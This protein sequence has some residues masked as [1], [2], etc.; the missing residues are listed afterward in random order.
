VLADIAVHRA[1]DLADALAVLAAAS[2]GERPSVLAGG[3]DLMVLLNARVWMPPRVLDIHGLD[4]LRGI[5]ADGDRLIIGALAT[6]Q[7]MIDSELVQRLSPALVEASLTVGAIQI[8]ARGTLG[9]NVANGS[10][11]G[12]TLPVL[13][14]QGC[15]V[16]LVSA[17]GER[18]VRFEDFYRGYRDMD[19]RPDELILRLELDPLPE[20]AKSCFRKVGT[21]MA[22]SISKLM[23]GAVGAV[24]A[25]GNV[26]VLRLCAGSVAPVPLRLPATEAAAIGLPPAEA[27]EAAKVAARLE[28]QPIDDVRSSAEYRRE[29]TARIIARFVA[30]L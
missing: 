23:I 27:A 4:E 17:A 29:V 14:A 19:I 18:R 10:P 13:M 24:G 1:D 22:Q 21:R 11:A 12:D 25:D 9:G 5:R 28:V 8:Q 7:E 20:G 3:T 6:Y 15:D 30:D 16:V 2:P 26:S